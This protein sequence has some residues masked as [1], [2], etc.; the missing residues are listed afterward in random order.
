MTSTTVSSGTEKFTKFHRSPASKDA[1][2]N[3]LAASEQMLHQLGVSSE[4]ANR[5]SGLIWGNDRGLQSITRKWILY[6]WW[7]IHMMNRRVPR[8]L[9][10]HK[11]ELFN[12]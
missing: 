5:V 6:H 10:K 8:P 4:T 1:T 11:G 7:I 2:L 12:E 3:Y 9:L